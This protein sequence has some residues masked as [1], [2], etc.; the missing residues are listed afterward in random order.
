M[1]YYVTK[2][3]E[4]RD[5]DMLL[6][7]GM[8][9]KNEEKYL[10]QCLTA[11][12]PILNSIDSELIIV[13]TGS[14]DSTVEIA[15]EFTD[16]VLFFEWVNDFSAAR[17]Y[18]LERAQG[19]WF[20]AVDADEIFMG[21][22]DIIG[23]FRSGEYRDY[24][25]ASFSVRN[26]S[27]IKNKS[28]YV[29]FYVP[30]L[31]KI[32]PDTRYINPVHEQ[33]TTH[34]QPVRLLRDV[35]E[36]YGYVAEVNKEKSERNVQLLL[37]RLET[38]EKDTNAALYRELF[39]SAVILDGWEEKAVE[40]AR[41]G[42]EICRRS[43]DDYIL[44]IFLCLMNYYVKDKQYEKAVG[45]YDEYFAVDNSIRCGIRNTDIEIT[46][47]CAIA[48]Y[49]L[50][51]YKEA[52]EMFGRYFGLYETI[53]RRNINTRDILYSYRY[54][55][56][57]RALREMHHYYAVCCI[58]TGK[59]KDA[60]K[61][62]AACPSSC[63]KGNAMLYFN[64]IRQEK[65]LLLKYSPDEIAT[66]FADGNDKL[67]KELLSPLGYMLEEADEN[68][69][70]AVVDKLSALNLK[71]A[72]QR[73]TISLYKAH[74]NG[75][76]GAERISQFIGKHGAACPGIL[77]ILLDEGLD[78][79][80][81]TMACEDIESD[82]EEALCCIKPFAEKIRTFSVEVLENAAGLYSVT[83]MYFSAIRRILGSGTD[84]N[85]LN[86]FGNL[87][88]LYLQIF[89]ENN[90]PEEVYAAVM[91]AEIGLLRSNG[92]YKGCLEAMKK[93]LALGKQYA[94]IASEYQN[95]IRNAIS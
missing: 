56:D 58:E 92:D 61:S 59:Y 95:I 25:S 43:G 82:V 27:D 30:R 87:G 51:R 32:L 24:N 13:D 34:R 22:D 16:K 77:Y 40:Y 79:S 5:A 73:Q 35:A 81:Y 52:Y 26:Y 72:R 62:F 57:E 94:P 70:R 78:V 90:I 6:T 45:L 86:T 39:E 64:R 71:S 42:I 47:F 48:L 76:A 55:S 1:C 63:Y 75:G 53:E 31:T 2:A 93:L 80:L 66:L 65:S 9:V 20:M 18:G 85:V 14:T 28:G 91:T 17:N 11:L 21:C 74:F 7:I 88:I 44:C 46:G 3:R 38:D 54:L 83:K 10:R 37:K 15:R 89:G 49:S 41:T 8:I 50:E 29:D 69:R 36:H 33:L 4:E 68:R 12:Q 84:E 60:E 23:F 67:K 19:E